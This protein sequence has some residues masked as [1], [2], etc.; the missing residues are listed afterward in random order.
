MV[1]IFPTEGSLAPSCSQSLVVVFKPI[2][3]F[4]EIVSHYSVRTSDGSKFAITVRGVGASGI[5]ASMVSNLDFGS[6]RVGNEKTFVIPII[7]RGTLCTQ[8]FAESSDQQ[9]MISPEQGMIDGNGQVDLKV[10]FIPARAGEASAKITI[11]PNSD[12]PFKLP[13]V[14]VPVRGFASYPDVVLLTKNVDFG[15][16]LF[17]F[18]NTQKIAVEN[19]GLVDAR[20]VFQS[21]HPCIRLENDVIVVP[22]KSVK[23]VNLVYTP[24]V[25][26][27]LS[28]KAILRSSDPRGEMS[29]VMMKGEVGVPNLALNPANFMDNI[30][31]GVCKIK[32][33]ATKTVTL[34][35]EGNIDL[36]FVFIIQRDP[37]V[38][39]D[40]FSIEPMTGSLKIG[41]KVVVKFMFRPRVMLE[42]LA[43]VTL[44]Y[45]FTNMKGTIRGTGGKAIVSVDMP[46]PLIDFGICRLE[47]NFFKELTLY[48]NG[49]YGSSYQLRPE[50]ADKNWLRYS[51]DGPIDEQIGLSWQDDIKKLGL[52]IVGADGFCKP[53]NRTVIKLVYQPF[54]EESMCVKFRLFY[55]EDQFEDFDVQGSGARPRLLL[56]DGDVVV[57][58][59]GQASITKKDVGTHPV[60]SEH[61]SIF[62]LKNTGPFG[63]EFL[64]QPLGVAEFEVAPRRGFVEAGKSLPLKVY[65]R[66]RAEDQYQVLLKILWEQEPIALLLNGT[67]GI[68]RLQIE[69]SDDKDMQ[70]K[71]LDFGLVP[72]NSVPEKR[73]HLYNS[74]LVEISFQISIDASQ[75][76][77]GKIGEPFA[78]KRLPD[79][80]SL[81]LGTR[82]TTWQWFKD[83]RLTLGPRNGVELAVRFDAK[84][85]DTSMA[86]AGNIS[87]VSSIRTLA[88]P[89]RGRS[90]TFGLS[91]RGD[92]SFG[93]I[94]NNYPYK[95][96]LVMTNTG[97]IPTTMTFEWSV[98][99]NIIGEGQGTAQ[100]KLLE[101]Y[102][103]Y[104][105]RS[106]WARIAYAKEK[107]IAADAAYTARDYWGV[108]RKVVLK[109]KEAPGD[110]N[111]SSNAKLLSTKESRM[112][113]ES[114]T[115]L[116]SARGPST[117]AVGM[118]SGRKGHSSHQAVHN[119]RRQAFYHLITSTVVSS[120]SSSTTRPYLKVEPASAYLQPFGNIEVKVELALSTEETFLSTLI[121]RPTVPGSQPYEIPL[122][123]TP[124]SVNIVLDDTSALNFGKQP[125]GE[126]ESAPRFFKNIGKKDVSWKLIN[127]NVG[128]QAIPNKGVLK[129][130]AEVRIDF[131]FSPLDETMQRE[132]IFFEPDCST[133]VRIP[134]LG[135]GG[136]AKISLTKYK[137]FD[138]G[139]CMI[140]KN[141]ESGLPITNEGNA[142]LHLT[143]FELAESMVYRRGI[144]W[145]TK[146]YYIHVTCKALMMVEFRSTRGKRIH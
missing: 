10:R 58:T 104:D 115:R 96:K 53:F 120:Q 77:I 84:L 69:F 132:P 28:T 47:R 67:G 80:T 133:P 38:D 20:L 108:I 49:N 117:S 135:G 68:G 62:H 128:L 137:R 25:V 144:T 14:I 45:K 105:P 16:A 50:P 57:P 78:V 125:I 81:R 114:M 22:A 59:N 34:A 109:L 100:V 43:R 124:K 93:D 130:G 143:T 134:F 91:H 95:R 146:R 51:K 74:G 112:L 11:H 61:I 40:I 82:R 102:G 79:A 73:F 37:S 75:F 72:N 36:N 142:I 90:G 131:V 92:M 126:A 110:G 129:A 33:V 52:D 136:I 31:F 107:K 71:C 44:D 111:L 141:T 103:T 97:S 122:T 18:P 41:E 123:A 32:E 94:A 99:G 116:G 140:G 89:L 139:F 19:R 23:E 145:P 113:G 24:T 101:N 1:E 3:P 12:E 30:D 63:V 9:F 48:N 5:L 121:C 83:L 64:L 54:A 56:L 88:L 4:C 17:R 66:P 21:Y 6:I 13:P 106:G 86:I 27:R 60:A 87:F 46:I 15:I 35:N 65:F 138:F 55:G 26:E 118:A 127:K 85:A 39:K 70:G 42:S 8:Y 98:V 76:T 2:L 7:N 119:K 29:I